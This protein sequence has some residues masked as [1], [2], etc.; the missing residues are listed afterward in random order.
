MIVKGESYKKQ[1]HIFKD[2]NLESTICV[3]IHKPTGDILKTDLKATSDLNL[4][5]FLKGRLDEFFYSDSNVLFCA[6]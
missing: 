5:V 6:I 4:I 3:L 2:S 1:A